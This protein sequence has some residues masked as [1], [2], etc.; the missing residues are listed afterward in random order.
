MQPVPILGIVN[1]K[2]NPGA[3]TRA[4]KN[5]GMAVFRLARM[6]VLPV[7]NYRLVIQVKYKQM[8][9]RRNA[10]LPVIN[11]VRRYVRT[12]DMLIIHINQPE[13]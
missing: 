6:F 1:P 2:S 5:Q 4:I 8:R 11:A 7:I 13:Q 10:A 12:R 9:L 3:V